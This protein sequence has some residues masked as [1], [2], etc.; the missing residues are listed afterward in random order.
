MQGVAALR[1]M[2]DPGLL[3][4][5]ALRWRMQGEKYDEYREGLKSR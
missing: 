4:V 2:T 5:N 1:G 3:I